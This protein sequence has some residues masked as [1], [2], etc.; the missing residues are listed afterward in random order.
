MSQ[1][2]KLALMAIAAFWGAITYAVAWGLISWLTNAPPTYKF[3][4]GS[5]SLTINR[6]FDVFL[7]PLYLNLILAV[8]L[9]LSPAIENLGY[10]R[11]DI[12]VV[13]VSGLVVGLVV[14][15]GSGLVSGLVVGLVVS[16]VV[17]L[18][19]LGKA[20]ISLHQKALNRL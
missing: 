5:F 17:S 1:K 10:N 6:W 13:L 18:V 3:V 15:L 12:G 2:R 8:F 19:Y 11:Y 16:L 14:G 7:F 4:I 9:W 20:L